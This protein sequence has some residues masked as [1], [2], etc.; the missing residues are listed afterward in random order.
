M[1]VS[2]IIFA[3]LVLSHVI[4]VC[5]SILMLIVM[6]LLSVTYARFFFL[7]RLC[8]WFDDLSVCDYLCAERRVKGFGELQ[9]A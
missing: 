5:D 1:T 6:V 2:P 8:V 9:K 4:I 7:C 3:R